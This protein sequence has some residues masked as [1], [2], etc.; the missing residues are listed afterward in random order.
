MYYIFYAVNCNKYLQWMYIKGVS[1]DVNIYNEYI[2]EHK[3]EWE[4][5]LRTSSHP[6]SESLGDQ[7][8]S[9]FL[10]GSLPLH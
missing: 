10:F 9:E 5:V 4:M 1:I 6:F 8:E 2:W 7:T 3:E